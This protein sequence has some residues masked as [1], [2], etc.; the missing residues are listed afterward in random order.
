MSHRAQFEGILKARSTAARALVTALSNIQ[1]KF[2]E[3]DLA[4]NW[5]T[6]LKQDN[7]ILPFGWYQPPP[8]GMSVLIGAPP[9]FERLNYQSLREPGN[10]PQAGYRFSPDTILY[11]Y[12][13]AIDRETLMIG[14]HVGTY[15]AGCDKSIRD[16]IHQGYYTTKSIADTIK[17]G[18]LFSDL[19]A[20]AGEALSAIGAKNNTYS[21]S[22]GLAS[23]IG[24]T[25][26]F[27]GFNPTAD[28]ID[29]DRE[30]GPALLGKRLAD[31]REF[32]SADNHCVI[33]PPCAFTIEPQIIADGLP[34]VSFHMIVV[35]IDERKF[36]I[37]KFHDI[38]ELMGMSDWI[39]SR[40]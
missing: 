29:L 21:M 11:P 28:D 24:H 36:I 33:S 30:D 5:L 7:A 27:F 40:P 2:S 17:A 38:F 16:W 8:H 12:F 18:M 15:Y 9:R 6:L 39:Y 34:M 22:G 23:D 19:H 10:F 31:N 37:E 25:I 32:L 4:E 3:T 26:P 35:F 13:S 1:G 14:D 20:L